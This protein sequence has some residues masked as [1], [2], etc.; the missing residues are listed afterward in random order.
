MPIDALPGSNQRRTRSAADPGK[1]GPPVTAPSP[2]SR[3]DSVSD[4]SRHKVAAG[5]ISWSRWS[6]RILVIAAG[7]AA[8]GWVLGNVWSLLLPVLLALLLSTVL[9][10]PVRWLR[11]FLPSA[12]ASLVVLVVLLVVL[13]GLAALLV[14]VV[15]DQAFGLA[16]AFSGGLSALREWLSGPPL[17]LGEHPIGAVVDEA[18]AAVQG[19][20][21][22]VAGTALT[23]IDKLTSIVIN[24]V[25]GVVLT[26]FMLKDGDQFLPWLRGWTGSTAGSHLAEVAGRSWTALGH[27]I[28]SQAAVAAVD[29][30]LIGLGLWI[31]GVPYVVPLAFV[32]F[33]GAFIPIVGAVVTGA[34]ATVVALLSG[35]IWAAVATLIIVI[36]VQQLEGNVLQPLILGRTLKMHPAVVIGAIALGAALYGIVGAFLAVPAVAV[37]TEIFR[38]ARQQTAADNDVPVEGG[39]PGT[40]GND[41]ERV[42]Q[43]GSDNPPSAG[44]GTD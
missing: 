4:G 18:V 23:I 16:D 43:K 40:H 31:I 14:Q 3:S 2:R 30:V 26:F 39:P 37:C 35:G 38:Y 5:L 42:N 25:L 36:V 41:S 8:A 7:M 15:S 13:V 10:H 19:N 34:I 6:A 20:S 22:L 9:W 28:L 21:V 27:F 12:V 24:V 29:A 1:D 33:F 11:R 32:I 44:D 17:N